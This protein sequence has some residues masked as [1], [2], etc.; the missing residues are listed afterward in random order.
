MSIMVLNEVA[1]L[2]EDLRELK[3]RK[4]AGTVYRLVVLHN[5]GSLA[6]NTGD[7]GGGQN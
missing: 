3:V 7:Q 1:N 2:A 5:G 4:F 6:M